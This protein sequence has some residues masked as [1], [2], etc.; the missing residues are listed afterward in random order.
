MNNLLELAYVLLTGASLLAGEG[1]LH[2][3]NMMSGAQI[4]CT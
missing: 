4:N 1:F 2:V 3:L